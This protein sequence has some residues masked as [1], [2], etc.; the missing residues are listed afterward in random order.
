MTINI[1]I[2]QRPLTVERGLS[3]LQAARQ[4]DIYI[5]T[6]CDYPGL[7]AHGSCRMCIVEIQGKHH[8][9][10]ACTTPIEEGM[11]ILTDSPKVQSLRVEL[12]QML[13]S[14]HPSG[15]LF[16]EEKSHCDECMVTVRKAGVTTGCRS[17]A[18]DGQCE[19]QEL[20]AKSGV[21]QIDYPV[22][23]RMLPVEKRDPFFDR[24]YNL[25]ILCGRCIRTCAELHFANTLVFTERGTH[26]VVGT[27]F[28]H[29]HLQA[30]CSF[31]GACLEVCPTGALSEKTRK[32]DGKP[33][34]ETTTTCPLC[35]IGCQISLLSR[36]S[37]VIGSL[38][39]HAAGSGA[40]CVKGRFGITELV[41]HPT[42]L[43]RPQTIAGSNSHLTRLGIPWEEAIHLAAEKLKACPPGQFEMVVSPNATSEDL[44]LAQ[45]F[46]RAVMQSDRIQVPALKLYADGLPAVFNLLRQSQPLPVLENA[47]AILC[48]GLDPK[49]SQSVVEV[50]LKQARARGARILTLNAQEHSLGHYADLWLQPLPGREPDLV[51][52]LIE[53]TGLSPASDQTTEDEGAGQIE[54]AAQILKGA[55]NP[56]VIVGSSFLEHPE[57]SLLLERVDCL[58]QQLGASL[59]VLPEQGNLAGTLLLG[60]QSAANQQSTILDV[61]YDMGEDIPVSIPGDPFILYQNIYPPSQGLAAGLMLPAA[62]FSEEEGTYINHSGRILALQPAVPPPGEAL[63]GWQIL[64]RIARKMGAAGFD[65]TCVADIQAEIASRV[66]N[67]QAGGSIDWTALL[68]APGSQSRA[69][70]PAR[71]PLEVD[72]PAHPQPASNQTYL[73]F[74]LT[75]WVAGMKALYP[76]GRSRQAHV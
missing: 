36:G 51:Q 40:L 26:A 8:C 17:C 71:Q 53:L 73:G 9:P 42:R 12:L 20:V 70:Q 67:F 41:N 27:A 25:C 33:E 22:R 6:L 57:N 21:T 14:E 56:A 72:D 10:T 7:P 64:A 46:S 62:A 5:P 50:K 61:L 35:S 74:P 66:G 16:C 47:K 65:Y 13:L 31:C 29:T 3:I 39:D 18:Q 19:L 75:Q 48:L 23:Y 54:Q 68:P 37:S 1:T 49:Y 30:G 4:N 11:V 45:K 44:Y 32:W 69:E 52:M 76:D 55:Q 28:N 63:P 60:A 38:P 34:R 58:V 15:C 43:K 59:I 2:N 24:D